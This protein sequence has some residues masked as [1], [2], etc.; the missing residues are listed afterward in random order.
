MFVVSL[1]KDKWEFPRPAT[2]IR[3]SS[4]TGPGD[5]HQAK[6]VNSKNIP[7]ACIDWHVRIGRLRQIEE[8][9]AYLKLF[10]KFL[11]NSPN[12]LVGSQ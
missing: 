1:T 12:L 3:E 10:F 4:L 11:N 5:C 8:K 2:N 9:I 6:R 7:K